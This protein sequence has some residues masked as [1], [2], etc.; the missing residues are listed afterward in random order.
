MTFFT[1]ILGVLTIQSPSLIMTPITS[2][3]VSY[4]SVKIKIFKDK[5][6]PHPD[7]L[8]PESYRSAAKFATEFCFQ[9]NSFLKSI[10]SSLDAI[11][12]LEYFDYFLCVCVIQVEI[13]SFTT[14]SFFHIASGYMLNYTN[15]NFRLE[16]V[17]LRLLMY[18]H[19][20][21]WKAKGTLQIKT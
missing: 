19:C 4:N 12:A 5:Y 13:F 18:R 9:Y 15:I 17:C 1:N 8:R 2:S 11:M 20:L 21:E 10:F 16:M 3:Q 6:I 14:C 7:F